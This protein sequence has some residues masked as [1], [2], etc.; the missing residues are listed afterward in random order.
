MTT[1]SF[2]RP[3]FR[4]SCRWW[5]TTGLPLARWWRRCWTKLKLTKSRLNG[6]TTTAIW[7][8]LL[9][10]ES[11][12]QFAL[13]YRIW[14]NKLIQFILKKMIFP[15][16][17]ILDWNSLSKVAL[18]M[19][20][21]SKR[22]CRATTPSETCW[23]VGST[24]CTSLQVSSRD[25]TLLS[26]ETTC[27]KSGTFSKS[28]TSWAAFASTSTPLKKTQRN[29]RKSL[30]FTPTYGTKIL[31]AH[32]SNSWLTTSRRTTTMNKTNQEVKKKTLS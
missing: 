15:H 26:K 22:M 12:R 18:S 10:R 17:S 16:S 9:L 24:T 3:F 21:K 13:P 5:R 23:R 20:Q 6:T 29:S 11:R 8:A 27:R 32:L 4:T 30:R 28:E 31:K 1:I 14:M 19:N 7:T 25:L 2:W